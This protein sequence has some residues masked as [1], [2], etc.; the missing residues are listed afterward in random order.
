MCY[1]GR[2][3]ENYE[4]VYIQ[5]TVLYGKCCMQVN[6][7]FGITFKIESHHQL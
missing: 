7:P 2:I 3:I 6:D 1:R 5:W 4:D